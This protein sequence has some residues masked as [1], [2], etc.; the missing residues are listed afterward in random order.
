MNDIQKSILIQANNEKFSP[1]HMVNLV[2]GCNGESFRK[3]RKEING[4]EKLGVIEI[5]QEKTR[6]HP[7]V[8]SIIKPLSK[9]YLR[10]VRLA[11]TCQYPPSTAS[12]N[13][14][15]GWWDYMNLI[16]PMKRDA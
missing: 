16:K 3:I 8:C 12:D 13:V 6:G 15:R 1:T 5:T 7:T 4:L 9:D 10:G 14:R 11:K 2:E